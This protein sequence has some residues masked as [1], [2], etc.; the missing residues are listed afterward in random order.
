MIDKNGKAHG[1]PA[2]VENGARFWG[3][4]DKNGEPIWKGPST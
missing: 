1:A 2:L 3:V 4:P